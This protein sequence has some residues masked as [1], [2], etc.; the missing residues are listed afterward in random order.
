M[1]Y[2]VDCLMQ[3]DNYADGVSWNEGM[4]IIN[5]DVDLSSI[6]TARIMTWCQTRTAQLMVNPN[7]VDGTPAWEAFAP[8]G[9]GGG[10]N[11]YR[12]REGIERFLITDINNPAASANSSLPSP[13]C[14]TRPKAPARTAPASLITSQEA[15][16]AC[17]W[18]VTRDSCA[19]QRMKFRATRLCFAGTGLV[20]WLN[21]MKP[22]T[23]LS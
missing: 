5:Q 23:P 14:G 10:N 15:P 16:T 20:I 12:L 11:I 1:I 6:D 19:I 8:T 9:N 18:T 21:P 22:G 4:R 17:I 7:L 3:M 13:S 2:S